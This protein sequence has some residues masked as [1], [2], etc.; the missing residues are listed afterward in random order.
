MSQEEREVERYPLIPPSLLLA[1][2]ANERSRIA[3]L[4]GLTVPRVGKR[5]KRQK[6][7]VCEPDTSS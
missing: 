2:G 4:K 3:R 1:L 6:W 5:H 7:R